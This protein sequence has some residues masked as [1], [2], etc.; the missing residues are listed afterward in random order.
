[1]ITLN[2]PLY[3]TTKKSGLIANSGY[4][5]FKSAV[6]SQEECKIE[7]ALNEDK[8]E[9]SNTAKVSSPIKT[10]KTVKT[11]KTDKSSQKFLQLQENLE[12]LKHE[13]VIPKELYS[14]LEPQKN[15]NGKYE[16]NSLQTKLIESAQKRMNY[17]MDIAEELAQDGADAK[18][19]VLSQMK[20]IFGGEDGLG[21]YVIA[22][23]KSKKSI[24]NKLVKEFKDEHFYGKIMDRFSK[25]AYKKPYSALNVNDYKR[26]ADQYFGGKT[27]T[28]Q[29][30][31]ELNKPY[32]R[33]SKDEKKLILMELNDKNM[34]FSNSEIEDC[35]KMFKP[36]SREHDKT[37]NY[38]KDLV[39]TRLVLPTGNILEL[40]QVEKYISKA[41]R[42]NKIKITKMS[43][44]H[45]NY[46]LPYIKYDT[47]KKWK[48]AIPGMVLVENS[49][50]RKRN[51]Y[52]TTQFNI[53]HP[54]TNKKAAKAKNPFTS[55]F[56]KKA[57]HIEENKLKTKQ[58]FGELQI[59]TEKL[60]TIGQIEHLIYDILE[61]KDISKGIPELREYYD[62]IGIEKAVNEVFND[63]KK[64]ENYI[65]YEN[66]MYYWIRHTET[67]NKQKISYLKPNLSDYELKDYEILGF[68]SLAE[69]DKEAQ[70]ILNKYTN[71]KHKG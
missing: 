20:E 70:K 9:K 7:P 26:I 24:F 2:T 25:D 8:F 48:E 3:L 52:T 40:E 31:D 29:Q 14:F 61:N 44:Y 33:L 65:R 38:V 28:Q 71:S 6:S 49:K 43:N 51:G 41:I 5:S 19:E 22:R 67:K 54:V 1:M 68:D 66:S 55:K 46:I 23:S 39:G 42:Y 45:D 10:K 35:I 17:Y 64:E 62:S 37:V 12:L 59:R 34:S 32:N 11:I 69:I 58:I 30:Y 60:N 47:A 50:V 18:E 27:F 21:K 4:L 13:K 57:Q 53:I 36:S 16:Y 63:D 15:K 56:S